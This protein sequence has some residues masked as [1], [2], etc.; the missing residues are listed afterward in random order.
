MS[1]HPLWTI[2]IYGRENLEQVA[3]VLSLHS[4]RKREALTRALSSFT[5]RKPVPKEAF[6]DMISR[7]LTDREMTTLL[8]YKSHSTVQYHLRRLGLRG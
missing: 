8:G 6:E 7:G 5:R 2:S 3:S 1:K 4:E